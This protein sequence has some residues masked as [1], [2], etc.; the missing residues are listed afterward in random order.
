MTKILFEEKQ[1]FRQLWLWMV[2][3][4]I[5]GILVY[6]M[7]QQFVLHIPFGNNPM[8]NNG[9]ILTVIFI[10][11]FNAFFFMLQLRT[12]IDEE[13]IFIRFFPIHRKYKSYLWTSICKAYIREYKPIREYGGWGL[14]LG[15]YNVSGNKGLQLEFKN[16]D[17]L[18][19]GTNKPDELNAVIQQLINKNIIVSAT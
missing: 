18:L 9:Y 4:T 2:L 13:G 1:S 14:R 17:K 12:R 3:L 5:N 19:I 16:G 8:S 10:M 11:V 15:A 7:F 6:G